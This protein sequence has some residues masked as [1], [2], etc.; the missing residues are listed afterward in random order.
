[1]QDASS[2]ACGEFFHPRPGE[3]WWDCCSGAGGKSMLLLDKEPHIDLWVSDRRKTAISALKER[4]K[5]GGYPPPQQ[6]YVGTV[7]KVI[8]ENKLPLFDQ[9]ITDL[10]CS[11]S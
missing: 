4:W 2:Q 3:K 8:A 1:I 9:I 7:A 5:L 10:P 6:A 11:G